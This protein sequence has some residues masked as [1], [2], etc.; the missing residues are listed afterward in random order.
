MW[1]ATLACAVLPQ[2]GI[3]TL[4]NALPDFEATAV[5]GERISDELLLEGK[6]LVFFLS[7]ECLSD[8]SWL[9]ADLR[10]FE[11]LKIEQDWKLLTFFEGDD[12]FAATIHEVWD[13]PG[14]LV[15]V[16][17]ELFRYRE[18]RDKHLLTYYLELDQAR[19][20]HALPV[21]LGWQYSYAKKVPEL[22]PVER[23][24]S[25]PQVFPKWSRYRTARHAGQTLD[26]RIQ[27][28]VW[29]AKLEDDSSM[30]DDA[31]RLDGVAAWMESW[32]G[33]RL[34]RQLRFQV[35]TEVA[36][37]LP[38]GYPA[39]LV[40][41]DRNGVELDRIE[42]VDFDWTYRGQGTQFAPAMPRPEPSLLAQENFLFEGM[43]IE[44][45][46]LQ[47][48]LGARA[49][50]RMQNCRDHSIWV[51]P[52]SLIGTFETSRHT[53][54]F[55]TENGLEQ[56]GWGWVT[57]CGGHE[58]P[59]PR[60]DSEL[61]ERCRLAPGE[62]CYFSIQAEVIVDREGGAPDATPPIGAMDAQIGFSPLSLT[63]LSSVNPPWP[64][65][66]LKVSWDPEQGV[67]LKIFGRSRAM[68]NRDAWS[69]P[70][71]FDTND[72]VEQAEWVNIPMAPS[73]GTGG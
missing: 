38:E 59:R 35:G 16:P 50:V 36:I 56:F 17:E 9:V 18:Y 14:Q 72:A 73:A 6:Y 11:A 5:D 34:G 64:Q 67:Q 24:A 61:V 68:Q 65:P 70:S 39:R 41:R 12:D 7:E 58:E 66:L 48:D 21:G 49:L 55:Q 57:Q 26:I 52:N 15:P 29:F 31:P 54:R 19:G 10:E 8:A 22:P 20:F 42:F 28:G 46:L 37:R 4:P 13:W 43:R 53:L 32:D 69:R 3:V 60:L 33:R 1:I 47:I 62:A 27:G 25:P 23:F 2:Q 44:V 30:T 45:E 40:W 51:P 63:R 71:L